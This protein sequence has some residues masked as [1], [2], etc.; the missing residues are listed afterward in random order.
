M[1][2]TRSISPSLWRRIVWGD[3]PPSDITSAG[4]VPTDQ[5]RLRLQLYTVFLLGVVRAACP[6]SNIAGIDK[7]PGLALPSA[8]D[9]DFACRQTLRKDA[10]DPP[11]R[12]RPVLTIKHWQSARLH[13]PAGSIKDK[14]QIS[15]T[16][17][18]FAHK[19]QVRQRLTLLA[20]DLP[21]HPHN[22]RP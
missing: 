20:A 15:S 22:W 18:L 10:I 1:I 7:V 11:H 13:N 16:V 4:S 14:F 17:T 2:P 21:K 9:R 6:I 5:F 12:H 3:Y 8:I 19:G